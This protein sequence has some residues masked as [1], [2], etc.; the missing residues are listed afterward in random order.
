MSPDALVRLLTSLSVAAEVVEALEEPALRF[1]Q[2]WDLSGWSWEAVPWGV[3]F[4][5][6]NHSRTVTAAVVALAIPEARRAE[7][8]PLYCDSLWP[9]ILLLL[10]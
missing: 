1:A 6:R 2:G 9:T 5:R 4:L 8:G 10:G 7:F 3:R